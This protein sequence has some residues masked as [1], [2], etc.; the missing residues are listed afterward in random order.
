[1]HTH[2]L[3]AGDPQAGVLCADITEPDAVLTGEPV[4]RL[5]DFARPVCLLAVAV[6]DFIP[7]SERLGRALGRYRDAAAPGSFLVV[8]HGSGQGDPERAAQVRRIYNASTSPLV[9]RE[10]DEV[11]ALAG[12]WTPIEPGVS[13]PAG[14]RP[15]G[16]TPGVSLV[17]DR[18]LLVM[19]AQKYTHHG[20]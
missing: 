6:A 5:I 11:R 13:N 7:D 9:V 18:S 3:L 1:M 8:S 20:H 10:R 16:R 17:A 14:W 12:D 2:R 4:R 19:V 15:D